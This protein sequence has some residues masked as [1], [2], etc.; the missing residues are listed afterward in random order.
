MKVLRFGALSTAAVFLFC[1][2][3]SPS[4]PKDRV[5]ESLVNLCRD[6]Y[7]MDVQAQM[8]GTTLGVRVNIPGLIDSL[9]HSAGSSAVHLPGLMVEG[10]Y[11]EKGFG[12]R[13]FAKGE[14][15]RVAKRDETDRPPKEP[16]PAIKKLQQISTAL[17]RVCLSTNA[18]IEFYQMIARDPGPD[19][20]DVI[21][22]GYIMDSKRA[23]FY[24]ISMGE[25]QSRSQFGVRLQPEELARQTVASFLRDLRRLPLPKLLSA[26]TSP[27]KRFSDLLPKILLA[28]VD[29][30]GMEQELIDENWPARQ[31]DRETALVYVP[32][33]VLRE[34]GAL[35]FTVEIHD[36]SASLLD[37]DRL[38]DGKLPKVHEELGSPE[39]WGKGFYLES[40]SLPDFL[41]EQIARRVMAEFQPLESLEDKARPAKPKEK[42]KPANLKDVTRTLVET[43]AYV[44]QSYEFKDFRDLSVVDAL[45]G[46]RWKVP[47]V[48]LPL[49]RRRNPPDLKP[50]P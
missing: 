6:E 33:L 32:L 15:V 5:A 13:V 11:A 19:N 47:A 46:T 35:L 14:F 10:R 38:Q 39:Q 31:I 17:N 8:K 40:L 7:K 22:S 42:P 45:K 24:G 29:L 48:D 16:E 1:S 23:Q 25:M 9:R 28:A 43:T 26:Y 18:P 20:L 44:T 41:A 3:S 4:Y 37:I 50:V 2:C 36:S 27:S 21:L 49:Y 12:F 34:E 30:K